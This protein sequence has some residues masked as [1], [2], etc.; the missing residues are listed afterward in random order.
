VKLAVVR[1]RYNPSGGAERFVELAAGAL[2]ANHTQISILARQWRSSDDQ[3][4]DTGDSIQPDVVTLDPFYVGRTWRDWSFARAVT[5]YVSNT[6]FDLVQSHERIVGL[7]IYRAGDGVHAAW[8]ARRAARSSGM[9]RLAQR[10][11]V[12]HRYLCAVE[13]RMFED[14][15]LRAVI[16][17]SQLVRDEILA[18][19]AIDQSCLHVIYNG[20]DLKRY[21]PQLRAQHNLSMRARYQL[22]QDDAVLLFIGS[23]FAR[24][25]LSDAL[26]AVARVGGVKLIVVG[27]DK[28]QRRY[29][30]QARALGISKQCHFTGPVGDPRP[31]YGMADGLILPTIYD[32]FPNVTLEALA[33]AVP[34]LV[35]DGS[36]AR[37]A[38]EE[39]RNGF[40]IPVGNTEMLSARV[41]SWRQQMHQP[42]T[43]QKMRLAACHSA[44]R[45]SVEQMAAQLA[46]LYARLIA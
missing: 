10:L 14:K 4:D 27:A 6:R 12:H 2:Q 40:V 1:A 3:G 21:N 18:R 9:S 33:S 35:S 36:G 8:L 15:R 46:A 25:G 41:A 37:E 7:D 24:K 16:C 22:A 38:V 45:F 44:E 5:S 29:L 23:G 20:V 30:D 26:L 19:F 43:A 32:P 42:A 34:I 11:S 13:R 17:N 31:Y 28:H 39:G